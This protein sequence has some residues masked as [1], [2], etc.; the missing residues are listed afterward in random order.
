MWETV[1]CCRSREMK[2]VVNNSVWMAQT[3]WVVLLFSVKTNYLPKA[4]L[5]IFSP[6]QEGQ[7][8]VHSTKQ[9]HI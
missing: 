9:K 5:F 3:S 7:L 8:L 6:L 1:I 4:I 2:N